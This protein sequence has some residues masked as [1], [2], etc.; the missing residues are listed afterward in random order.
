[1]KRCGAVFL[2]FYGALIFLSS[3][4]SAGQALIE[5]HRSE[6]GPA[7]GIC[8]LQP[9]CSEYADKA[10]DRDPVTGFL[11]TID[12]LFFLER[13]TEFRLKRK[14]NKNGKLYYYD[15][16]SDSFP[17]EGFFTEPQRPSLLTED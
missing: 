7:S 11:L 4:R 5:K 3:C 12:R 14:F 9:S 13:E 1:M 15:P 16:L 8:P 6:K 10:I 2:F 17:A